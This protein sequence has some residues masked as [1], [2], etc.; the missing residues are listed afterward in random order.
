[1]QIRRNIV[2]QQ[3]EETCNSKRL[4]AISDDFEVYC[5]KVEGIG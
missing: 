5:M 2:A 4:V 3:R 1:M